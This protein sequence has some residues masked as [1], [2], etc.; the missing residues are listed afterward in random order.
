[1]PFIFAT[2]K[3]SNT[4]S[5]R[6]IGSKSEAL[7]DERNHF[8]T[9]LLNFSARVTRNYNHIEDSKR[10]SAS[11]PDKIRVTLNRIALLSPNAK[12]LETL[13]HPTNYLVNHQHGTK[14]YR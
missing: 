5:R 2:V 3:S 6:H 9:Q 7:R 13:K 11:I 4:C 14:Y 10:S 8:F 12:L 1:M